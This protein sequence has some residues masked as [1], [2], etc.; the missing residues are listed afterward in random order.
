MGVVALLKKIQILAGLIAFA[1]TSVNAQISTA[2]SAPVGSQTFDFAGAQ[3]SGADA[4]SLYFSSGGMSVQL[5]GYS[6]ANTLGPATL[7]GMNINSSTFTGGITLSY[8]NRGVGI[9]SS[10][11]TGGFIG[12]SAGC[13]EIDSADEQGRKKINVNE[14]MLLTFLNV[15]SVNIL[16]A[17]LNIVDSNDTLGVYGVSSTGVLTAL[18]FSGTIENPGGGFT[19]TSSQSNTNSEAT[20]TFTPALTGYSRYL[21]TTMTNGTTPTAGDGYRL[22][23]LTAGDSRINQVPA[24]PEPAAWAMMLFGFGA[25]GFQM[26]RARRRGEPATGSRNHAIAN[27]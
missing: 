2:A 14:G 10:S 3:S 20:L 7:G 6:F 27:V 12:N 18:G 23:S 19:F 4:S 13:P 21:F 17:I 15:P 9:C 26:R 1:S 16:S 22:Q 25:V 8:S 5:T 11:E 24:V